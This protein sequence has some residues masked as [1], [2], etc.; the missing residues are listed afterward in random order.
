MYIDKGKALKAF[1]EYVAKYNSNDGKIKLKIVHTINVSK[2]CEKI[3]EE[4]GLSK[5]EGDIAF[6]TGLLHDIGRFEQIKRYGT[7]SDALSVN[8]AKLGVEILFK[9]GNIRRFLEDDAED[10]LLKKVIECHN[11]YE[12]PQNYSKREKLFANILRDADK[13]D[14]FRVNVT[15]PIEDVYGKS[16][17]EIYK[18]VVSEGVMESFRRKETVL[19]KLEKTAVDDVVSHIAFLF[20]LFYKESVKIAVNQGYLKELI[21]FKSKN[22]NTQVQFKEIEKITEAYIKE[23]IRK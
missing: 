19:K 13:L 3:A 15:D 11:A 4:L 23:R 16:K 20:G 6:I 9:E 17:E 12:I 14:I 10:D 22:K 2:I 8:H 1:N 18:T 5:E 7:F 21:N